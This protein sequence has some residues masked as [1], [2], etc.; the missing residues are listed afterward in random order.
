MIWVHKFLCSSRFVRVMQG[1]QV[2]MLALM[3]WAALASA[4]QAQPNQP[5][6]V[7]LTVAASSVGVQQKLPFRVILGLDAHSSPEQALA[8]LAQAQPFDAQRVYDM[9]SDTALWLIL[10]VRTD[11]LTQQRWMINFVNTFLDRVELHAVNAQGQWQREIAGDNVAHLQWSQ[12]A[13]APQVLLPVMAAGEQDVLIK[14]VHAFP[15]KIPLKLLELKDAQQ[16]NQHDFLLA[17]LLIG[18]LSVILLLA[19]HLALSYLDVAYVWYA[20]YMLLAIFASATHLGLAGYG[21][22]PAAQSWPEYSLLFFIWAAVVA[23]LWF[24][25]VMF[26][27]DGQWPQLRKITYAIIAISLVLA[28]VYFILPQVPQRM[29]LFAVGMVMNIGAIFLIVGLTLWRNP[30][31]AAYLWVIAYV[32]LVIS[33]ILSLLLHFSWIPSFD[34]PFEFPIY[35]LIFEALVLLSALHLHAKERHAQQVRVRTV[36]ELDALTGFLNSST[37]SKQL[38][39][40]WDQSLQSGNDLSLVLVQ[41]QHS[42]DRNDSRSALHLE[43]KI[44]RT[45]RL[46]RALLRDVDIVGRIGGNTLA[47]ALPGI[48]VGDELNNRLTR[49]IAQG[50]MQ[51]SYDVGVSQLRFHIAA[52]SRLTFSNSLSALDNSLRG[53][54]SQSTG[55]SRKPI[56][57]LVPASTPADLP[58]PLTPA[59]NDSNPRGFLDSVALN[60]AASSRPSHSAPPSH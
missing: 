7:D 23:Q 34:L 11:P 53:E 21:F 12:R 35:P 48:P 20:L 6:S 9:S 49:L 54:I 52:G 4:V 60:S 44:V 42:T 38:K 25:Q 33:V 56:H 51:D 57:Y 18:L 36:A 17:G 19:L 50:L 22:W 13:L 39:H 31:R 58:M 5:I 45:S 3:C 30:N 15:Q 59:P 40:L 28:C 26:L 37:F 1:V 24:C 32:P 8:T 47:I 10:R 29:A 43:H 16:K 41:V 46:L 2:V 14:L 55:W 27:R